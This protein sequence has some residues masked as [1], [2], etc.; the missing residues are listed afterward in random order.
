MKLNTYQ[1]GQG[2]WLMAENKD[3]YADEFAALSFG[4]ENG[5]TL[6][7]TAE[8][9]GD[10]N[11]ERL[12]GDVLRQFQRESLFI[13]SK[14]Y[15]HNASMARMK[16][17]CLNSLQRLGTSYLDLY[18]LHWP[19]SVPLEETVAA[20]ELLKKEDL[21]KS[22]GVSNFD[23]AD[24]EALWKV[25][26]GSNC[27]VDQVLYHIASRGIEYDLIPWLEKHQV[28]LMAYAPLAHSDLYRGKIVENPALKAVAAK[29][30]AS[31]C[32]VMLAFAIRHEHTIALPKASKIGH[33]SDN[34]GSL[35]IKLTDED[36]SAI[37]AAFPAPAAKKVLDIL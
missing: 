30:Q 8:M 26:D 20:F 33:I 3:R 15:P 7:D 11:A 28:G 25:P 36:L 27:A 19:G 31:I 16:T 14:V 37:D 12:V 32:Q 17:A 2:T 24:M 5:L 35:R 23:V 22:W 13:V 6:I 18:L 9:Y 10:G 1:L 21:I 4:I 34:L 29:Y